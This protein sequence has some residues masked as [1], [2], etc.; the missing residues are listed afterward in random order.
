MEA[1][2]MEFVTERRERGKGAA[3][4]QDPNRIAKLEAT[5]PRETKVK[6]PIAT[7]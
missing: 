5:K 4:P 7:K 6:R 3:I 1:R 2:G